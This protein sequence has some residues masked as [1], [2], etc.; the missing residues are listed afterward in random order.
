MT[1]D[2]FIAIFGGRFGG[3]FWNIILPKKPDLRQQRNTKY[4]MDNGTQR[5]RIF[6]PF[7]SYADS[8]TE[9]F[10]DILPNVT[11]LIFWATSRWRMKWT[12][13]AT[14]LLYVYSIFVWCDVKIMTEYTLCS[15]QWYLMQC[16]LSFMSKYMYFVSVFVIMFIYVDYIIDCFITICHFQQAVVICVQYSYQ[17]LLKVF[18]YQITCLCC[19]LQGISVPIYM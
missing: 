10:L 1:P 7:W 16:N 2:I 18:S 6:V 4:W 11:I 14:H 12:I 15:P 19:V 9:C 8:S 13:S 17:I 3:R 5:W